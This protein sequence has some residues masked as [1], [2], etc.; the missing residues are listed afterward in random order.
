MIV[1]LVWKDGAVISVRSPVPKTPV[2]LFVVDM[3]FAGV[4]YVNIKLLF[5]RCDE[6]Y[7]GQACEEYGTK[8]LL[9]YCN[10][11][12][13]QKREDGP[14]SQDCMDQNVRKYVQEV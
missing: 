14:P 4:D 2:V 9:D 8:C 11:D 3:V 1:H 13:I 7:C 6:M 10:G 12:I 5:I